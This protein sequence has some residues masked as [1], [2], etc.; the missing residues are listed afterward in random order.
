MGL[1][2]LG[3]GCRVPAPPP[4]R[5]YAPP[6]K[7]VSTPAAPTWFGTETADDTEQSGQLVDRPAANQRSPLAVNLAPPGPEGPVSFTDRFQQAGPWRS[8]DWKGRPRDAALA[9]DPSRSWPIRL[10][11]DQLAATTVPVRP[12]QRYRLVFDGDG[13]VE[14]MGAAE[15]GRDRPDRILFRAQGT[16]VELRVKRTSPSS[17]LRNFRMLAEEVPD[18]E[19]FPLFETELLERL[20]VFSA[21][22]FAPNWS[23]GGDRFDARAVELAAQLSAAPWVYFAGPP[24]PAEAQ[25]RDA[26]LRSLS[27]KTRFWIEDRGASPDGQ[28]S[29]LARFEDRARTRSE[30]ARAR[31]DAWAE[32]LGAGRLVRVLSLHGEDAETRRRMLED[33]ELLRRVDALAI[34]V[35]VDAAH[36][37]EVAL[38][39]V[40]E[41][42]GRAEQLGLPLVASEVRFEEEDGVALGAFLER[43]RSVGGELLALAPVLGPGRGLPDLETPPVRSSRFVTARRFIAN[44]PRW[45]EARAPELRASAPDPAP[46]PDAYVEAPPEP[47]RLYTAPWVKWATLGAGAVAA[48][49]A[50]ERMLYAQGAADRRDEAL[51]RLGLATEADEYRRLQDELAG[52]ENDRALAQSLGFV[53]IGAASALL[54]WA[55]AQWLEEPPEPEIE[56]PS[57]AE[58]YR[59]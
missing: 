33:H 14:V 24:S 26:A 10:Q 4:P 22:R 2:A 58:G 48:G 37:L 31:F 39:E 32:A 15:V 25:A 7:A 3:I 6:P 51:T 12:G 57:W 5:S 59:P 29:V 34:D 27:P 53:G 36:P 20:E 28:P 13:R 35:H 44:Q 56:M 17:P 38:A 40:R 54:G 42:A 16:T 41:L 23:A 8:L 47:P 50:A 43:W 30:A 49:F 55:L 21:L 9:L 45:W 46:V 18:R 11:R 52:A 1:F 19:A